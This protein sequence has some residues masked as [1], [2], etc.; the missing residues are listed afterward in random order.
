[1]ISAVVPAAAATVS[2]T[3][4]A[5]RLAK[6]AREGSRTLQQTVLF[7]QK[8]AQSVHDAT[9]LAAVGRPMSSAGFETLARESHAAATLVVKQAAELDVAASAAARAAR[10]AEVHAIGTATAAS[11]GAPTIHTV[12]NDTD[13]FEFGSSDFVAGASGVSL[14]GLGV[15][16]LV[17]AAAPYIKEA[18]LAITPGAIEAEEVIAEANLEPSLVKAKET[19]EAEDDIAIERDLRSRQSPSY[20]IPDQKPVSLEKNAAIWSVAAGEN[21]TPNLSEV[22]DEICESLDPSMSSKDV[23]S[24]PSIGV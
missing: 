11:V 15:G 21:Y 8:A 23:F 4:R 14:D 17:V 9:A 6:I 12:D 13:T 18:A 16:A 22:S 10:V 5:F 20:T 2:A 1:M 19:Y 7:A 3:A 24:G